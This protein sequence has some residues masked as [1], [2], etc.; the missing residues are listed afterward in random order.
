MTKNFL[1]HWAVIIFMTMYAIYSLYL[2]D[3]RL[4]AFPKE[5]DQIFSAITFA[6]IIFF[7]LEILLSSYC[8]DGFPG[9][10]FFWIDILS[11]LTMIPDVDWI[12]NLVLAEGT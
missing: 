1:D 12:W 7:T 6:G 3:V 5:N 4:I 10:F 2:D 9:S 11:T 8:M